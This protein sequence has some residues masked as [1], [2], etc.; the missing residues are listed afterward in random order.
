MGKIIAVSNQKG[1]VGKSTTV[2]NL[3]AVLG[4]RGKKVLIVDFDP[5]GNS[6]TSLG[7][8]KKS[9][10]NT[11]YEVVMRECTAYE[12]VVATEFT[13]VSMIPT[14]QRLSGASVSL[15][16]MKDKALQL[17]ETIAP[18]KDFYDY[19]LIDC[20]PTLDMLTINAL[21]AAD[22][23]IVPIQCEFLSLEGLAEL[24]NTIKRVQRSFNERLYLEGILFTMYVERYKVTGQI[25][26]EVK[27]YF[28]GSVFETV[29]PRNIA[30]SEAPSFGK[31]ALYYDKKSKGSKAYEALAKEILRNEKKREKELN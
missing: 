4:S 30:L 24:N 8:R 5:Q 19:I 13:G 11:I 26:R 21:S 29:I 2:V 15:L 20:P 16:S 18:A 7:V 27:K 14:T 10:R 17:R 31:P 9:V 22:S 25:V 28:G 12:A 23:V 1:G 6:T 3:A